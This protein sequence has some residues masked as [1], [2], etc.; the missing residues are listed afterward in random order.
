MLSD[1]WTKVL[2]EILQDPREI[3]DVPAERFE[4][5]PTCAQ[6]VKFQIISWYGNGGGLQYF[7]TCP[8]ICEDGWNYYEPT[9][10]CYKYF[11][12][13]PKTAVEADLYCSN[14]FQVNIHR[15]HLECRLH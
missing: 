14:N 1:T 9:D 5:K 4:I 3:G 7:S 13:I 2:N 6:F 10:K 12:D 11:S 15:K 8:Q